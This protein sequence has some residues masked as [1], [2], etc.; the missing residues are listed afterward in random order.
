MR[1]PCLTG[2][3]MLSCS[4]RGEVYIPS[5]FELAEYCNTERRNL[6][7]VCSYYSASPRD[8]GTVQTDVIP[9]CRSDAAERIGPRSLRTGRVA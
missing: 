7:K 4:A 1:C 6:Y 5:S 3:Y 2:T 9:S 8:S